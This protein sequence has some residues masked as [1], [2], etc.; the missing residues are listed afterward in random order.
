MV[1]AR[2]TQEARIAEGA[3]W[4]VLVEGTISALSSRWEMS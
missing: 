1:S 3:W 2:L 4:A